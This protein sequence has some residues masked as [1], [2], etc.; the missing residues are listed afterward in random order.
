VTTTSVT[1]PGIEVLRGAKAA[2]STGDAVLCLPIGHPF[3]GLLRPVVTRSGSVSPADVRLITDWRNRFAR[4]FLSEFVATEEQTA[5][6]LV[7]NVGSDDTR[8]LFMLETADGRTVGHMGLAFIDWETG[9]AETDSVV[10]AEP[11][12]AGLATLALATMWRWGRA[13]LG[14]S[15]L[16][17]RVRSDN[18]AIAYYE[19]AGFRE[20]RRMPLRRRAGAD[21]ADWVE[22][23]AADGAELS[24]V[25]L[26]LDD[27]GG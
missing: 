23:P 2:A 24:L 10:R 18:S 9:Y 11:A 5:S 14:L 12:P 16:G 26:E 4:S 15:R 17:V 13:G 1:H 20:V 21:G 25:Y 3:A 6:W 7:E 22:D 27:D 8:I 19:K